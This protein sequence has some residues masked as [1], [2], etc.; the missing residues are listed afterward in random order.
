MNEIAS[1]NLEIV[2]KMYGAFSKGDINSIL[3]VLSPDVEWKEPKNPF[4]PASGTRRGHSGFLEWAQIGKCSEDILVLELHQFLAEG[5]SVVVIGYE[6][7]RSKSTNK[8]YDSDFVHVIKIK[9]GEII[10]LQEYFDTYAAGEAFK[11]G[12]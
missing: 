12:K 2:K 6:K 7:C 9:D 10:L 1:K 4:N 3:A 5:D 8:I 11:Q